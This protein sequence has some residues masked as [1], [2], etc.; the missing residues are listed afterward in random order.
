M[1]HRHIESKA[2]KTKL[3]GTQSSFVIKNV[4]IY[5]P[6][7]KEK[8]G[9]LLI[10]KEGG[11][12]FISQ[13]KL[14]T[15]DPAIPTY[16][17]Q[18][19]LTVMPGMMDSHVHGQGGSDFGDVK[20]IASVKRAGQALGQSG[21]SYALATLPS[22]D[23]NWCEFRILSEMPAFTKGATT[24]QKNLD[25]A[26]F[27]RLPGKSKSSYIVVKDQLFYVDKIQETIT[28][29][30]INASQ[31]ARLKE[32]MKSDNIEQ[33]SESQLN[34]IQQ[35][36]GHRHP[37]KGLPKVLKIIEDHIIAE[38]KE[39]IQGAAKILGVHLEGPFLAHNCKGAH[40]ERVLQDRLDFDSFMSIINT[41][42]KI[43]Q[44][45]MTVAP[46]LPGAIKFMED[47]KKHEKELEK[48]G[49]S[50]KINVGHS[51]ASKANIEKFIQLGAV[52]FTHCG[53]ACK[54][55]KCR[56]KGLTKEQ[57]TSNLVRWVIDNGDRCPKGVELIVDGHHLSDSFV[58][59]ITKAVGSDKINLVTDALGPA[60]L[61]DGRYMLGSLHIYKK[62][63]IFYL[64][65]PAKPGEAYSTNPPTLAGGAASLPTCASLYVK[66]TEQPD[67]SIDDRMKTIYSVAVEN[68]RT[69]SLSSKA[70]Q[71]LPED[72]NCVLLDKQ[73]QLVLSVCNGKTLVD[74]TKLAEIH[75]IKTI[76][77]ETSR[78]FA[79][80]E[81]SK[82]EPQKKNDFRSKL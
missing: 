24:E 3:Q 61:E 7:T 72:K 58:Q 1:K 57:M 70:I 63:D 66:W 12:H 44:W 82:D 45:K 46:D 80:K 38:E 53:N 27:K 21:L 15:L 65:D 29:I 19:T 8:K 74:K 35:I 41:V 49:I 64:A 69:S 59:V 11:Y 4:N 79:T 25:S 22:M 5:F 39:P 28:P 40:D 68:P 81:K 34:S 75:K 60:G 20:D 33:L 51:N 78:Q 47:L 9:T 17:A 48:K 73:G 30:E 52:G 10:D 32:T 13:D 54:E 71:A 56:E 50:I 37:L 14:K 55:P 26:L 76:Q 43:T 67:H 31:L 77:Q 42:P 36:T 16:D 18:Q 6:T 62:G 23:P 2:E